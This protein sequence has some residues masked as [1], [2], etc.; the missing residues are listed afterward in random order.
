MVIVV[1]VVVVGGGSGGGGDCDGGGSSG[2]ERKSTGSFN[3]VYGYEI[4]RVGLVKL[5]SNCY[6]CESRRYLALAR[7]II[8]NGSYAQPTTTTT[9]TTTI[10]TITDGDVR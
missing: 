4:L 2:Y 3:Q 10:T 1:V 8:V 6:R 9:T 5:R 7:R